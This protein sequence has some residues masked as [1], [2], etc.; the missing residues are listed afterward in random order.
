MVWLLL[1]TVNHY[2]IGGADT[3]N[4]PFILRLITVHFSAAH[5]CQSAITIVLFFKDYSIRN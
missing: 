5:S 1:A 4:Q 3:F 2:T